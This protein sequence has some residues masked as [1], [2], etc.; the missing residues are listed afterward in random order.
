MAD[1]ELK[2]VN[3]L[4]ESLESLLDDYPSET[5]AALKKTARKFTK[6]VNNK[7]PATYGKGKRP[8]VK[9]WKV[10]EENGA[11]SGLTVAVNVQNTAPHFHLVENGHDSKIPVSEYAMYIKHSAK[12]KQKSPGKVKKA[13]FKMVN[14]GFVPGKHYCADTRDEWNNGKFAEECEK[15]INKILKGKN[16]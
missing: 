15:Q 11:L 14:R 7:F 1:F 5:A 12:R 2:G 13:T 4:Q 6:D 16:L 8:M 9:S 3:E 10:R